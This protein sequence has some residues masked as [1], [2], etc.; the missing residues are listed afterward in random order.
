[1]KKLLQ[2]K[3]SKSA[4]LLFIFFAFSSV[5]LANKEPWDKSKKDWSKLMVSTYKGKHRKMKKLISRGENV[6]Y[7]S[8]NGTN[9]LE[10]AIRKRDTEALNILIQS[11]K[12]NFDDT[13]YIVTLASSQKNYNILR[14]LLEMGLSIKSDSSK[15]SPLMAAA[16]FGSNENIK[17]LIRY[18]AEVNESRLVDGMT[19]L[20]LAALDCS[21]DKVK[22]LLDNGADKEM[23]SKNGKTAFDYLSDNPKWPLISDME[24]DALRSILKSSN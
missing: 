2:L 22:I 6:N 16:S 19:S 7:S 5:G 12:L 20:M 4:L 23:K 18:G 8:K 24:K 14:I 13:L 10:I 11:K 9:A 3:Q 21:Y 17:L 1:M 15:Y